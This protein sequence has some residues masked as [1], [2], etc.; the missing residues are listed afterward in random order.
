MSCL[1]QSSFSELTIDG[2]Y[3]GGWNRLVRGSV[4]RWT[5]LLGNNRNGRNNGIRISRRTTEIE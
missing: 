4:I 5:T 2:G 3:N 1:P